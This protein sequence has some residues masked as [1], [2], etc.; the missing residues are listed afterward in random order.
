MLSFKLFILLSIF[1]DNFVKIILKLLK[2]YYN[3]ASEV[4]TVK[5]LHNP[6]R[7]NFISNTII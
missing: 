4:E 5:I 3:V 6:I 7:S 2:N 1:L